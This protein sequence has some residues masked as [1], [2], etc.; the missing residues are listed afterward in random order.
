MKYVLAH[1]PRY[2]HENI[3]SSLVAQNSNLKTYIKQTVS[4]YK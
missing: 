1:I 4:T 2:V 3:F